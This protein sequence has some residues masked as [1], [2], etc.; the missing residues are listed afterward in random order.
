MK[1]SMADIIEQRIQDYDNT[2]D[3]SQRM[4]ST[5]NLKLQGTE[6]RFWSVDSLMK[7]AL[8]PQNSENDNSSA[9]EAND[10]NGDEGTA[11]YICYQSCFK[12]YFITL[13]FYYFRIVL[14]LE[15]HLFIFKFLS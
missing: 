5:L 1:K 7:D 3:I 13:I 14:E 15:T 6:F 8:R 2:F 10:K 9:S 12:S 11:H 4:A